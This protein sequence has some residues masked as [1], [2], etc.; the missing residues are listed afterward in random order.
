MTAAAHTRDLVDD[1]RA[2]IPKMLA[3]LRTIDYAL[4]SSDPH[5]TEIGMARGYA[6]IV[7][8]WLETQ[9]EIEE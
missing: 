7:I 5:P 6:K 4:A 9:K 8:A 3:Y 1:P 2:S